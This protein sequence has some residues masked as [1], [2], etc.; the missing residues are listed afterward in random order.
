[1]YKL[2][3]ITEENYITDTRRLADSYIYAYEV[4]KIPLLK[5]FC[6]ELFIPTCY[7]CAHATELLLKTYIV[8]ISGFRERRN[9]VNEHD[10]ENL[11]YIIAKYDKDIAKLKDTIITLNKY[12][13]QKMRYADIKLE[14]ESYG[15]DEIALIKNVVN[16][17]ANKGV[18]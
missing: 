14:M 12:S 11:Q 13:G 7:L 18:Y 6:A 2:D 5:E 10:L 3:N 15:T 9:L 17:L 16:Y 8:Q 4:L 1:M